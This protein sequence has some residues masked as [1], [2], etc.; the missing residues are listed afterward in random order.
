[1]DYCA[2][3][4]AIV[5]SLTTTRMVDRLGEIYGVP[6]EE[7]AVGFKFIGPKKPRAIIFG[8]KAVCCYAT[9]SLP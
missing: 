4:G 8:Q 5:R 3:R 6:V 2:D 1:M 9:L 7:T